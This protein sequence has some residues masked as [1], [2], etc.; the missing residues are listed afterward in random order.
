KIRKDVR[1]KKRTV[2]IISELRVKKNRVSGR[3][4]RTAKFPIYYTT[5][6][7]DIGSMVNWMIEEKFWKGT[8]SKVSAPEFDFKGSIEDLIKAIEDENQEKDLQ[9]IVAK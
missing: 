6:L 5:G 9:R 2:G 3:K 8:K 1:G 4:D 7:D